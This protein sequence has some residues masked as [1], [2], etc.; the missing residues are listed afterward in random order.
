MNAL[1]RIPAPKELMDYTRELLWG[2]GELGR[3]VCRRGWTAP[4]AWALA[5]AETPAAKSLTDAASRVTRANN[6]NAWLDEWLVAQGKA[7]SGGLCLVAQDLLAPPFDADSQLT[8]FPGRWD[9]RGEESYL[10]VPKENFGMG[11]V[12]E[13]TRWMI[14]EE[15]LLYIIEDAWPFGKPLPFAEL[16]E[17]VRHVLVAVSEGE[18]YGI[19]SGS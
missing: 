2:S 9:V 10:V 4:D 13:T 11:V 17:K 1:A 19:V 12:A 6:A 18:S 8:E 15:F 14:G 3:A 7:T 16:A 5:P